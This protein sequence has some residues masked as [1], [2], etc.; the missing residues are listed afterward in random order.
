MS[1]VNPFY[2]PKQQTTLLKRSY[3]RFFRRLTFEMNAQP[4]HF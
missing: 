1:F 3:A 2:N 4:N